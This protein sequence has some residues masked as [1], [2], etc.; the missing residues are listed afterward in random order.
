MLNKV[1]AYLFKKLVS[2]PVGPLQVQLLPFARTVD[3]REFDA[4]LTGHQAVRL[5]CP[6]NSRRF[7]IISL[8]RHQYN[9]KGSSQDTHSR[10]GNPISPQIYHLD[11]ELISR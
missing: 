8:R 3:V 6:V 10:P 1:A 2:N 9:S 11:T 4:H 7:I 5:V